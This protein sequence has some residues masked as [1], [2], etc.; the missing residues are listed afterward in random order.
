MR[1]SSLA[2]VLVQIGQNFTGS[3]FGIDSSL[4]PPDCNGAAGPL[5]YVELINGRF[6]V[7]DKT[8]GQRILTTNSTSFWTDSGITFGAGILVSD[9][10]LV[11]DPL[12]QRWF[13]SSVDF[14][15]A[16][17]SNNR[18]LLAISASADPTGGWTGLAFV[19]DPEQGNFADFPTLGLD[20]NGVYLAAH[21]FSPLGVPVGETLVSLPK[22]D[23]LAATPTADNRTA[24]G[25]LDSASYGAVLEPAMNF[26]V[27]TNNGKVLA[28]GDLGLDHAIHSTLAAFDISNASGPGPAMLSPPTIISV[29]PYSV[30][31]NPFQPDGNNTL[32]D[33][34]ARFSACVYQSAGIL[35][36]V[37]GVQVDNRA[38]LRWYK[39]SPADFS[40]LQSG[41]ITDPDLD[42]F[43]PSIAVNTAGIVVICFNGCSTGTFVSSFVVVG[44]TV[45]GLTTFGSPLLLKA[46]LASYRLVSR[47][48]VS[49]WGDY[50]TT[51]V[52]PID[53]NRFWTI[54]MY[55]SDSSTWSTQITELLT[56]VPIL[57]IAS[58]E[59]NILLSW[60]GTAIPFDLET[61]DDLA[62]S[63]WTVVSQPSNSANGVVS[64][65]LPA[66]AGP[67]FFRLRKL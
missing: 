60:P 54:Q 34:D 3:T 45:D 25:L 37:H 18:F 30:P 4:N 46:G 48:G 66:I 19:A 59:T 6:S 58:V 51:C 67:Q 53:P 33:G 11:F 13:S 26:E 42:L 63:N 38:A 2:E 23:L 36:A 5:H 39:I 64:V 43:Y 44:E 56:A 16:N 21:M 40:V 24:F 62:S 12:V 15:P 47:G 32:D 10:R 57:S 9:P 20:E 22:G 52:D 31:I 49:R 65:Q 35:Y 17:E 29:D 55:P 27:P 7:Y 50:S 41:T 28:V 61:T 8:S 1:A 14:S